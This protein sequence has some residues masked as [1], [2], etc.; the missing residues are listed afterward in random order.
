MPEGY[1]CVSGGPLKTPVLSEVLSSLVP[2]RLKRS[3]SVP[4]IHNHTLRCLLRLNCYRNSCYRNNEE[5]WIHALTDSDMSAMIVFTRIE[6]AF[7]ISSVPDV[8]GTE[9]GTGKGKTPK[10]EMPD[11]QVLGMQ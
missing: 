9:E 3:E 7:F 11:H 4:R 10:E 2:L 6:V 1:N 5:L 8:A